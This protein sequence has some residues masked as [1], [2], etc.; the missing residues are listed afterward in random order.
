MYV[1]MSLTDWLFGKKKEGFDSYYSELQQQFQDEG[2]KVVRIDPEKRLPY[3]LA[4]YLDNRPEIRNNQL[5]AVRT[6]TYR[7]AQQHDL[8]ALLT[9]PIDMG[10]GTAVYAGLRKKLF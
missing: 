1:L 9:S 8:E 7:M 4:V 6:F 5:T 3:G 2:L 10:D